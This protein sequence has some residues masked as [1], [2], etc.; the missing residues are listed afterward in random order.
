MRSDSIKRHKK[1][2]HAR[3]SRIDVYERPQSQEPG[4]Q[5]KPRIDASIKK[6]KVEESDKRSEAS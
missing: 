4:T 6:G 5:K 2:V 3:E 1:L